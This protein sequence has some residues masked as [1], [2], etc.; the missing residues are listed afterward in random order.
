[1]DEE[2]EKKGLK[3]DFKIKVTEFVEMPN[4]EISPKVAHQETVYTYPKGFIP[5]DELPKPISTEEWQELFR[6]DNKENRKTLTVDDVRKELNKPIR[7]PSPDIIIED[8]KDFIVHDEEEPHK[9]YKLEVIF[10]NLG[11][12]YSDDPKEELQHF[13]E[14]GLNRWNC[15]NASVMISDVRERI[16]DWESEEAQEIYNRPDSTFE[17]WNKIFVQEDFFM[18]R[19]FKAPDFKKRIEQMRK[20]WDLDE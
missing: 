17:E 5:E 14:E 3:K 18:S 9:V 19:S 15:M 6:Y 4:E 20:E 10:V 13:I 11:D 2:K 16:I 7:G 8:E 1:M 12:E